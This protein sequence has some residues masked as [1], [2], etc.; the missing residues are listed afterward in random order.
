MEFQLVRLEELLVELTDAES[1]EEVEDSDE[2]AGV[3]FVLAPLDV[4]VFL[5]ELSFLEPELPFKARA[6]NTERPT[7]KNKTITEAIIFV[8]KPTFIFYISLIYLEN[9]HSHLL[10]TS[11]NVFK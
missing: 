6:A 3:L 10:K 9:Y 1:E 5:T 4:T 11:A 8:L 2:D 7:T